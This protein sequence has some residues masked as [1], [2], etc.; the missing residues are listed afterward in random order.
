[1][2]LSQAL[3][4]VAVSVASTAILFAV[5]AAFVAVWSASEG[6]KPPYD[7]EEEQSCK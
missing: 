4:L 6:R 7:D 2:S 3:P 5:G 1:M